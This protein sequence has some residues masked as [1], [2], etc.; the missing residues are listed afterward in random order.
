MGKF[1][2][3]TATELKDGSVIFNAIQRFKGLERK[4]VILIDIGSTIDSERT[5]VTLSRASPPLYI[6]GSKAG[7][8]RVL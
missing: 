6:V 1:S 5:Y 3:K 2:I 4:V 8:E 7:A